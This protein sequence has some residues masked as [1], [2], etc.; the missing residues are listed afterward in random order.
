MA[1][2]VEDNRPDYGRGILP[3]VQKEVFTIFRYD[4]EASRAYIISHDSSILLS[5][6]AVL[7]KLMCTYTYAEQKYKL[8]G[9]ARSV[10]L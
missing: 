5:L 7:C 8:L 4:Q 1:K 9:G 2:A 6:R 10:L 3:L